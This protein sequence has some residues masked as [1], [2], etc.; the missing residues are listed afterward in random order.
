MAV[1]GGPKLTTSGL[2][3]LMDPANKRC[4]PGSGTTVSDLGEFGFDGT[5]D[6]DPVFSSDN[7]GVF[8]LDG[9]GDEIDLGSRNFG[10]SAGVTTEF[11][12]TAWIYNT[13][14]SVNASYVDIGYEIVE[15]D[16]G[17]MMIYNSASSPKQI[18]FLAY[19]QNNTRA[20]L[21]NLSTAVIENNIW[22][23]IGVRWK[24]SNGNAEGIF[25]GAPTGITATSSGMTSLNSQS[26]V[27]TIGSNWA[28]LNGKIGPVNFYNRY[29]SDNEIALNWNNTRN[30]FGK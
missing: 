4:Y 2:Q 16:A 20:I 12:L 9:S 10:V 21:G 18:R 5:L 17:Q 1:T 23:Y 30:R 3:Y 26:Q 6:G 8:V 25:D 29:L 28:F 13:N 27:V 15:G 19:N 22:Y 24:A 11:T 14:S 7:N